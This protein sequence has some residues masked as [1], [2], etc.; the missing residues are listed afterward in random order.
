M[1]VLNAGYGVPQRRSPISLTGASFILQVPYH[2]SVF[3]SELTDCDFVYT[4]V[5]IF[6]TLT[7]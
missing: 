2:R 4:I 6:L 7:L 1:Q 3:P 5:D